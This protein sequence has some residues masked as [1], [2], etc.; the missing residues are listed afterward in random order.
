MTGVLDRV[1]RPIDILY[2]SEA[3][4]AAMMVQTPAL[5]YVVYMS[6]GL[7]RSGVQFPGV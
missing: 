6:I 5:I 2:E 4:S 1:E 7:G 3:M